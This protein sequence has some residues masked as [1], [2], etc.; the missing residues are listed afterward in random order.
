[1]GSE[2]YGYSGDRAL[3]DANAETASTS[4]RPAMVR[5]PPTRSIA[6][7]TILQGR[8]EIDRAALG[9]CGSVEHQSCGPASGQ[10]RLGAHA[11]ERHEPD[12]GVL[13]G[14]IALRQGDARVADQPREPVRHVQVG[15]W[16]T[17]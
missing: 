3:S 1:M 14:A 8:G 10:P 5:Q 17:P 16:Y 2:P 15:P 13:R 7:R 6:R 11:T 9:C 12:V 4:A